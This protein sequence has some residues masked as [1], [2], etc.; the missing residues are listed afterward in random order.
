VEFVPKWFLM[1][2]Q[3]CRATVPVFQHA[4][5]ALGELRGSFDAALLS[6]YA[7]KIEEERGHD[8]MMLEDL[9][10]VGVLPLEAKAAPVNPFIAEM[11]G[12]QYYLSDV[13]HPAALLGFAG[14]LEGFP[15]THEQIEAIQAASGYPSEA[16]S[17]LRLHAASDVEHRKDVVA[18]LDQVPPGLRNEILTNGV[19]CAA[20]HC[21]AIGVL[22]TSL[23]TEMRP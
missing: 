2:Y 6:L 7:A 8:E 20:L 10:R 12:R 11:V 14:L 19:R 22:R 23:E 1:L 3:I 21:A 5:R 16:F 13:V 4:H 18:M 17:T 9:R 15:P